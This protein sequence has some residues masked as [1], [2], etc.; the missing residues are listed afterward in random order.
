MEFYESRGDIAASPEQVWDILTDA[1]GYTQWDSGV[2][3]VDG[4]VGPGETFK[5]F[6]SVDPDR[7]FKTRVTDFVPDHSMVWVGGMPL[8]ACASSRTSRAW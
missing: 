4:A 8:G 6:S 5:I 7:G 3:R 1:S 2:V